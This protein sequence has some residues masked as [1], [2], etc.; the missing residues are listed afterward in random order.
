MNGK[1]PQDA[2]YLAAARTHGAMIERLAR[3]Y[4]AEIDGAGKD[5]KVKLTGTALELPPPSLG[6]AAKIEFRVA[7]SKAKAVEVHL[8]AEGSSW[9][10]A[11][12]RHA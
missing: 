8:E 9:K 1:A 10:I 6:K 5:R 7:G 2:R 4:E 3:G 11:R 12:V